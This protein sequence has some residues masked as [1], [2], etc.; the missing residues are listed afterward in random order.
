MSK[1]EEQL[2][3]A[4]KGPEKPARQGGDATPSPVTAK[5]LFTHHDAHP[6][7]LGAV[8]LSKYGP[9]YFAWTPETLWEHIHKDFAPSLPHHTRAKIQAIRTAHI[10]DWVWTKWEV[11][12]PVVQALNNNIPDFKVLRKPTIPQLMVAVDMLEHVRQDVEYSQE[13][14]DFIA[15]SLFDRGVMYAPPPLEFSQDE[16]NELIRLQEVESSVSAVKDRYNSLLS[17]SMEDVPLEETAVDTQVA[18]LVVARDYLRMR[19]FQL[20]IQLEAAL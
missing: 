14:Q 15:A 13:V 16:L 17:T 2:T 3:R 1:H 10:T 12:C 19:R 4:L 7:V 6:L 11:F 18:R 9:N 8:L 20:K 5:N